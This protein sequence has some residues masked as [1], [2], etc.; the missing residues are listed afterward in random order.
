MQQQHRHTHTAALVN[1]SPNSPI[2]LS[3]TAAVQF[4]FLL[5]QSGTRESSSLT[6]LLLR[7]SII[8]TGGKNFLFLL[9]LSLSLSLSLTIF[10]S[11]AKLNF[12]RE[13]GINWH[14]L[15]FG[16]ERERD[17]ISIHLLL[18]PPSLSLQAPSI[19][20]EDI[21]SSLLSVCGCGAPPFSCSPAR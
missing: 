10:F 16:R 15:D 9:S 8:L 17:A 1:L 12:Q 19:R 3:H 11:P 5:L 4:F 21:K 2:S 7:H 13:K 6:L 18:L 20:S 14:H